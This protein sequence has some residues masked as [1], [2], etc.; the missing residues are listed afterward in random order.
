VELLQEPQPNISWYL[1]LR[2]VERFR[3]AYNR[4]PGEHDDEV[5][6]DIPLLKDIANSVTTEY[7]ISSQSIPDDYIQEM[8][9]QAM[10]G[11]MGRA[12]D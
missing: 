7:G 10:H 4:Y 8:Y 5:E 1:L 6:P 2:A 11:L 9:A 12:D 3:S